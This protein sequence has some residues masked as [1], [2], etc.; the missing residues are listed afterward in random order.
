MRVKICSK[1]DLSDT[2]EQICIVPEDVHK[3]AFVTICGMIVSNVMQQGN[4]NMPST[5]QHSM[6]ITFQQF[7]GIF[8]HVYLY[9]LFVYSN[10]VEEH[11]QHLKKVFLQLCKSRFYVR[12]D[13]CELFAERIDCLGHVIYNKGL[14]AD[15][16]KMA[17]IHCWNRLCNYNDEQRFLG[18]VQYLAHFLPDVTAY[19][20]LLAA[21]TMNRTPFYWRPLHEMCFQM[22]KVIC[23]Q[24]PI[25]CLI[26]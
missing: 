16:D 5:F 20:G 1:L 23:C 4:C 13:K 10:T 17:K 18:L 9:N 22:I 25:L 7:I 14:H 15:A 12:A 11:Q 19:T 21:M 8:L 6:N 3:T 24:M 2:Y 26:Q